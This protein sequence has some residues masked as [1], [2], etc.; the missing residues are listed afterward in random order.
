MMF[1]DEIL[2]KID[3]ADEIRERIQNHPTCQGQ[4]Y[5][6]LC[7]KYRKLHNSIRIGLALQSR[8]IYQES[9]VGQK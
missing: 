2:A 3:E 8:C 5:D 7:R 4:E 6:E 1:K 9:E